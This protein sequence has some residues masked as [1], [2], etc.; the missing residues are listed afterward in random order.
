MEKGEARSG[1]HGG[2]ALLRLAVAQQ[3]KVAVSAGAFQEQLLQRYFEADTALHDAVH[4]SRLDATVDVEAVVAEYQAVT[5]VLDDEA[6]VATSAGHK[7][8]VTGLLYELQE[9]LNQRN[10][11]GEQQPA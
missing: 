7:R 11:G 5:Q 3:R 8:G 2:A 10:S 1:G 9:E 6:D 4:A